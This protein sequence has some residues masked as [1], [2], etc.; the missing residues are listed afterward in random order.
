M[1]LNLNQA[2]VTVCGVAAGVV[3]VGAMSLIASRPAAAT[4]QF[5]KDT[6]KSCADC[7]TAGKGGGPLTPFGAK[8]KANGNKLPTPTP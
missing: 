3:L 2:F 1:K 7:H 6:G 5:A 8:F 4:M